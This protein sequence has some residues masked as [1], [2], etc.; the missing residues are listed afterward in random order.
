MDR[1]ALQTA[2]LAAVLSLLSLPLGCSDDAGG[3]GGDAVVLQNPDVGPDATEFDGG[4]DGE[5]SDT[6]LP[7]PD[8]YSNDCHHANDGI[9]DE[10]S[11]CELGTDDT[12]CRRAC[13]NAET[14]A[15][16]GAACEH[17]GLVDE[18]DTAG[19]PS[20][21]YPNPD[22]SGGS[23]HLTGWRDATVSVPSG[24][25]LS[26]DIQRHFRVYVP[27]SYD[28]DKAHPVMVAMPGHRVSHWVLDG[29]TMLHRTALMNDF[30]V[31]YAGQEFRQRWA[32]WTEWYGS[33]MDNPPGFCQQN[34]GDTNPDY[35]FIRSIVDWTTSEYNVDRRRIYLSGHSRGA[36]MALMAALEM[37]DRIAGAAVQS[38]FTEC[39][40]LD[41]VIGTEE[42]SKRTVPL[43]FVHGVEDDDICINC[44]PGETCAANPQ[45]SCNPGMH[46]SDPIVERLEQI[47]WERGENLTY[48]RLE[49]VA[50]RWQTQLNQ[51][52]WDFLSSQ[53]LPTDE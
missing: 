12:D 15:F 53:P 11:R 35:E 29:Y 25:D 18:D 26:S 31:V 40:Y 34:S 21:S 52:V 3:D 47:G 2:T 6:G 50:H 51:H 22:P 10:P 46:A 42:W 7:V 45:R 41:E 32:F 48:F 20:P 24:E 16:I 13:R 23:S 1:L 38:G 36:A 27:P 30:I 49:R 43:A 39:G 28:P 5:T 14:L 37:P 33:A 4:E 17:R 9:C 19:S 8:G 44:E